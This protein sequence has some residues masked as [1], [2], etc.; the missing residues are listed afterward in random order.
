ME[1][2]RESIRFDNFRNNS[3]STILASYSSGSR[4]YSPRNCV[5][6]R[7]ALSSRGRWQLFHG[8][9]VAR[10]V[11]R[12]GTCETL[13]KARLNRPDAE[14]CSRVPALPFS[15]AIPGFGHYFGNHF[16]RVKRVDIVENCFRGTLYPRL[17]TNILT[18]SIAIEITSVESSLLFDWNDSVACCEAKR[19]LPFYGKKSRY[20]DTV[21]K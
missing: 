3:P 16:E 12:P 9:A 7:K 21:S 10:T 6:F 19:R 18:C 17:D 8:N 15:L 11:Q 1:R 5:A 14:N 2:G 13:F 4:G 20:F